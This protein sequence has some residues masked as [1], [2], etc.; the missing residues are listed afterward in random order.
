M[1]SPWSIKMRLTAPAVA[2]MDIRMAIS[3]VFSMTSMTREVIMENDPTRMT[4]AS[5]IN[6]PMRS[7]WSA[8]KRPAFMSIQLRA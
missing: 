5:T 2:P 1:I 6:M 4:M 8:A 3:R 7:S